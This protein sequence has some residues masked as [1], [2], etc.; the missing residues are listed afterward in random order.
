MATIYPQVPQKPGE[1]EGTV[2]ALPGTVAAGGPPG[3]RNT[4]AG[5]LSGPGKALIRRVIE[6]LSRKH[7]ARAREAKKREAVGRTRRT[8]DE[9]KQDHPGGT[10]TW[11]LRL[12]I[13]V[14]GAA[15][16]VT[17]YVAME[18]LVATQSLALGLSGLT[19]AVGVGLAC[20][21]ATRR[22]N[23]LGVPASVRSLEGIFVATL[24]VLRFESLNIQGAGYPT[25]A[26]AAGLAALISAFGLLGIEE[27]VVETRTFAI[28]ISGLHACW[29]HWRWTSAA[30]ALKAAEAAA[31]AAAGKLQRHYLEYLLRTE[32]LPLEEAL[33]RA[34]A[35][36]VALTENE[37]AA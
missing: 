37:D 10:R 18:V 15:E 23:L 12:L 31:A 4:E 9:R 28:F 29:A 26:G 27:I 17:A 32:K 24:T 25:A 5:F 6:L 33:R 14:G 11:L 22:L 19:A 8:A 7:R 35:L 3:R 30:A 2:R 20:I 1:T 36:R 21:L 16:A 13:P 34:V